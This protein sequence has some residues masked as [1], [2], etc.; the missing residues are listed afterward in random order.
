MTTQT[1]PRETVEFQ[2]IPITLDGAAYAGAF[3]VCIKPYGERPA[4]W[5]AAATVDGAKGI[6]ISGLTA[7]LYVVWAKVTD[8]PETPVI[9]CGMVVIT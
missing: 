2:P 4:G 7:G 9:D 3:E 6:M 8:A 5:A 1:Y